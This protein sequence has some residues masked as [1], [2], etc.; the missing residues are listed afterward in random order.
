[1]DGID[2]GRPGDPH[3]IRQLAGH[4]DALVPTNLLHHRTDG[5][6]FLVGQGFQGG[7]R[8][9]V[10]MGFLALLKLPLVAKGRGQDD[11][12]V[13]RYQDIVHLKGGIPE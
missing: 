9:I 1:M 7:F 8:R 2:Q 5:H 11:A 3:L 4:H 13:L 12:G 6:H 10:L